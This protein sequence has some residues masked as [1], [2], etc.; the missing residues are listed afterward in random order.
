MTDTVEPFSDE[1]DRVAA[2]GLALAEQIRARIKEI[3]TARGTQS[4]R[5]VTAR[6]E[7]EEARGWSLIEEP[8]EDQI[9]SVTSVDGTASLALSSVTARELW[10]ARLCFD[11]LDCGDDYDQIDEVIGRLFS[12]TGGDTGVTM[13]IMSAALSTVAAVV[14]P[15]LLDEIEQS[16]ANWDERVRLCAARAKAWRDRIAEHRNSAATNRFE[17]REL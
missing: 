3:E 17:E 14:V 5:L 8:F 13:V 4:E 12:T 15:Q 7:A 1:A 9:T 6:A 16:G 2:E 10:G 11:L